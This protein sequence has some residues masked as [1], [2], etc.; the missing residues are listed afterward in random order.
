MTGI[1]DY[2]RYDALG[3]ARLVRERQV[4]AGELLDTALERAAKINP[5]INAIVYPMA[6]E[7]RR[8]I[9]AGVP[10][11]PF[12]GVPYLIKDFQ[13]LYRGTPTSFGSSFLKYLVAETDSE[14]VARARRAGLVTFGKTNTPEF[15]MA[16]TTE[17]R[18]FGPTR[19]PWNL[20][21]SAGGS[22]GGAAAA[23]AAGILPLAHATDG[24]GS[25]RIPASACGLFGLK[26][27]RGRNSMGPLVGEGLAG[28]AVEHCVSRSVRDSAALLDA[29]RG[30]AAGDP[31]TAPPPL[32][33]YLSEVG[34]PPG[35]LRI[36]VS[37]EPFF[38]AEVHADCKA[39]VADA[40]KLCRDLGHDVEE[41]A[42]AVERAALAEG[43]R[44][45]S[46]TQI[47]SVIEA[48]AGGRPI[49]PAD[50]EPATWQLYLEGKRRGG[51][52]FLRAVQGFHRLG[53]Q[54][55]P[56][57]ERYDLLLTPT[58]GAPPVPIGQISTDT[59]SLD[60]F[61][62]AV[63]AFAPFTALFNASGLPAMSVPLWWNADGLPVGVQFAAR[64]GAEGV[65]FRMAAQLEQ[66]RPWFE[67][68]PPATA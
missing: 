3:L 52:E 9:A 48:R 2:D 26:P 68:R 42:P 57:F 53:R 59:D 31:Y 24:G 19:N 54:V 46:S 10:Q 17:P 34:A 39:A 29:T 18:L 50:F 12:A 51:I 35:R 8:A 16:S 33:P 4:T 5:A 49:G 20:G 47:A 67:R 11:G 36:A 28:A 27:S 6:E 40:A 66:A 60:R 63:W 62:A 43:Y 41:A 44:V 64:Y 30:Y 32:H 23:V 7:A 38:P 45:I 14:M 15:A 1:A 61:W 13:A 65:L 56:F 58:L 37:T 25:I 21:R 55:A 22:S